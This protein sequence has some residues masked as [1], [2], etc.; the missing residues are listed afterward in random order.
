MTPVLS[1]YS[2]RVAALRFV[3]NLLCC[4][5]MSYRKKKK[6]TS[7]LEMADEVLDQLEQ[8][9]R[10]LEKIYQQQIQLIQREELPETSTTTQTAQDLFDAIQSYS[11]NTTTPAVSETILLQNPT[12]D[13][14]FPPRPSNDEEEE[15]DDDDNF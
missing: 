7:L 13:L 12:L 14:E 1:W 8:H 15:E 5:T 2:P 10:Q 11:V 6:L 9:Q 3:F 4:S